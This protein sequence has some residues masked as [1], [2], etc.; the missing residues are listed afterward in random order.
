VSAGQTLH[1][2]SLSATTVVEYL[3]AVQL[4][5]VLL[6]AVEYF[7]DKHNVQTSD[8]IAPIIVEYLPASQDKQLKLL[9]TPV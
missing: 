2:A 6:P 5:H 4:M 3:P 9:V 1:A 8:E 7:P